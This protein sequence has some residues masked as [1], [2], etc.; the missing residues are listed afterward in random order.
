M[1]TSELKKKLITCINHTDNENLLQEVFR[2]LEL[3][4]ENIE[5][6]KL[7]AE[8]KQSIMEGQEDIKGGNSLTNEEADDEISISSEQNN[9]E[10]DDTMNQMDIGEF[11][12]HQQVVERSEKWVNGS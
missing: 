9:K 5:V 8:Q 10:I 6:Y 7:T 2:L 11:I 12:S 4:T 1:S 3:E